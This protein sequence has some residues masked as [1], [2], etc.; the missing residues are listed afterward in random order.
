MISGS[1]ELKGA[2]LVGGGPE[3]RRGLFFKLIHQGKTRMCGVFS[4]S[5]RV[6]R[7][8][9]S[10]LSLGTP[11][12]VIYTTGNETAQWGLFVGWGSAGEQRAG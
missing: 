12:T 2:E 3:G 4:S 8:G 7:L 11:T 1:L 9:P 5:L 10:L 6:E